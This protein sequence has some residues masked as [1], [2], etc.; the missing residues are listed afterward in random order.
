MDEVASMLVA[1]D[2]GDLEVEQHLLDRYRSDPGLHPGSTV[3]Q[4]SP[5]G[6]DSVEIALPGRHGD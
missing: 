4:H 1:A 3:M 5:F 2:A 6:E